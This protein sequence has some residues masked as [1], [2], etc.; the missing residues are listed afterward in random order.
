MRIIGGCN[1]GRKLRIAKRGIRPTKSI[2]RSAIFNIIGSR[3]VGARVLDIFSGSGA[4][5]IEAIS[6]GARECVFIEKKP[7][8][9]LANIKSLKVTAG[10][11]VL[12]GDYRSGLKKLSSEKFDVIFMDPPYEKGYPEKVLRLIDR[13]ALLEKDGIAVIEH[14][15]KENFLLPP[16][17]AC[18]KSRRYGNTSLTMVIKE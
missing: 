2:V 18:W 11:K 13:Y 17:F 5:G 7:V 4:L 6:R 12:K 1:R 10:A 8:I 3:I 15:P 16:D 14:S 9:L